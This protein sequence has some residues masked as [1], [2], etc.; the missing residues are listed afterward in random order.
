MFGITLRQKGSELQMEEN[1]DGST[2]E[3]ENIFITPT[4][5]TSQNQAWKT[6]NSSRGRNILLFTPEEDKH[7]KMGLDPHGFG[8]WTAILRD[9]DF[10]FQKGRKANSLLKRAVRKFRSKCSKP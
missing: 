6:P 4:K 9:P 5:F 10:Y 8:N 7:L 2:P 1:N 3:E